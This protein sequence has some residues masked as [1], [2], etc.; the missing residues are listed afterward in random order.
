MNGAEQHR[1]A[2]AW[3]QCQRHVH[4]MKHALASMEGK[5]PLTGQQLGSLD[6]EAIQDLDQFVLRFGR[7]QDSIGSRLL[8]AILAVLQ[9]PYE[10]RPMID[11]LNRLEKLGFLESSEQWQQ[12]RAIRNGFSHDYP[13]DPDKNAALLNLA[14]QSVDDIMAILKRIEERLS[15]AALEQEE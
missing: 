6:D 1:L 15:P 9:E 3:R 14:I 2:D 8:P 10:D 12:L 11:K 7:L 4:H 5:L 13:D